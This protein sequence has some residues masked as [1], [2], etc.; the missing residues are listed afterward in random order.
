MHISLSPF[1]SNTFAPN[2]IFASFTPSQK[3]VMGYAFLYFSGIALCY[4]LYRCYRFKAQKLSQ[5]ELEF[6]IEIPQQLKTSKEPKVTVKTAPP[7]LGKPQIEQATPVA[8]FIQQATEKE[9]FLSI[10]RCLIDH[11][12]WVSANREETIKLLQHFGSQLH[13]LQPIKVIANLYEKLLEE[14]PL[15]T[16]AQALKNADVVFDNKSK[17]QTHLIFAL[18]HLQMI[19]DLVKEKIQA[20]PNS[21]IEIHLPGNSK[22]LR[23]VFQY[24]D[25]SD[26][27]EIDK[28][29]F[30]K[31]IEIGNQY[32]ISSLW[33]YCEFNLPKKIPP[34]L[35]HEEWLQVL[36]QYAQMNTDHVNFIVDYLLL[37]KID[38]FAPEEYRHFID[39]SPILQ[40]VK[41]KILKRLDIVTAS[42]EMVREEHEDRL[43]N[44]IDLLEK[45]ATKLPQNQ[46]AASD[47]IS[48]ASINLALKT[49]FR[50]AFARQLTHEPFKERIIKSL[51]IIHQ[52]KK[53][54][55][56]QWRPIEWD[57]EEAKMIPSLV[58][59]LLNYLLQEIP[60]EIRE[61]PYWHH[62]SLILAFNENVKE[63]IPLEK[64][65][66]KFAK[67]AVFQQ[68]Q[69]G[70]YFL[71]RPSSRMASS[72]VCITF[73][74]TYYIKNKV[75]H[76]RIEAIMNPESGQWLYRE[77]ES[78]APGLP[79]N[80][81][82]ASKAKGLPIFPVAAP[83]TN[84]K[85]IETYQLLS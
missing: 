83:Q 67:N 30:F 16:S 44:A 64:T 63:K 29:A 47:Y 12:E 45:L 9:D 31:L 65:V 57:A 32:P 55:E 60:K 6:P 34:E 7:P 61:L 27:S 59:C 8:T 11:P 75:A 79:L 78:R 70:F 71:F 13:F 66:M 10:L 35:E 15:L 80:D 19:Q 39:E 36:R 48:C 73:T 81:F 2:K 74:M 1:W 42:D 76:T 33:R 54:L 41:Q 50:A 82:I 20:N 69:E 4:S 17:Y 49:L 77:L 23:A 37:Q 84:K 28:I 72:K 56:N 68:N 3:K 22:T 46:I 52:F 5:P 53:P 14:H 62:D 25:K 40:D 58:A 43:T 24:L 21:K 26:P 85:R 18:T 38:D 51:E